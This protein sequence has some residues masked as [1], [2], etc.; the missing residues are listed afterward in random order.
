MMSEITLSLAAFIS[1]TIAAII[2]LGG[3]MVLISIV[4]IF[5][6][7]EAIIPVHGAC[8]L[9]SNISRVFFSFK[10]VLWKLFPAFVL[11]SCAGLML[12][13]ALLRYA[14]LSW[15][16]IAIG[17]YIIATLWIPG[18][19]EALSRISNAYM[20]G[21][22]QT[23]AGAVVGA[24]GPLTTTLILGL[25]NKKDALV[26]TNA[27]FMSFSH[28]VKLPLFLI[29]GFSYSTYWTTILGMTVG[30]IFGSY[31]GTKLRHRIQSRRFLTVL[32][33]TLTTLALKMI[34]SVFLR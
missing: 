32:K 28:A 26:S 12:V 2:G 27:L 9:A 6:P 33:F 25:T 7:L 31:V 20:I 10:T 19:R 24:T 8:Q 21:A 13:W 3:G 18:I 16:P 22:I 30:A 29:L 23:G 15:L 1:S 17:T 4:P 11:G 14:E 34:V 5:L